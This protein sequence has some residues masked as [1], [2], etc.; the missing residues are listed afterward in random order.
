MNISYFKEII[1]IGMK[2]IPIYWDSE[3][4]TATS[5]VVE[6]SKITDENW[7][8]TSLDAWINEIDQANGIAIKLF[9]PFGMIDFDLKNTDKKTVFSDWFK[10]IESENESILHKVCIEST[11]NGGYHVYLKYPGLTHKIQLAA[12][13]S[14]NEVAAVYT[15]SLLSYCDPTPG[16]KMFHNSF[17][18]IEELT[19]DEFEILTS[20]AALFNDY[21]EDFNSTFEPVEYPIEYE[22]ACFQFDSNISDEYFEV[23]LN[24]LSLKECTDFKYG[25][26]HKFTAY[27]RNGSEAA[28]SAKVYF[29]SRRVLLFTTSIPGFPTWADYKGP[30]DKSWVLS[31]S[32][33]IYYKN[34]R[35]WTATIEEIKMMADSMGIELNHKSIVEQ[36]IIKDRTQFPY[37]IFP[38]F[39]QDYI[40]THNIQHEYIAGFMLASITAAIGNTCFLEAVD[41]Y[42]VKPTVYLAVVAHAGG[43][44]SPA[45]R[46][47]FGFLEKYDQGLYNDYKG[48]SAKY[49]EDFD[50]YEKDK[51]KNAKPQKPVL[52]QIIFK[53]ATIEMVANILQYNPKGCI[54]HADELIGFINRMNAYKQG[55][56]LQKWLSI[57][58]SDPILVQRMTRDDN[59]IT[60]YTCCIAGGIQ[61]GVLSYLSKGD[62]EH[63]G[64]YHRF[65][66]VYPD[67]QPKAPFRQI[68]RS[69]EVKQRMQLFF[70]DMIK[71]RENELKDHY[72]LMPDAR[73][74]YESWCD[75]KDKYYDKTSDDNVKGI[76]AKYQGYCLRFCL[77]I[78]VINDGAFR[79]GL[80][81]RNS[82]EKA[83][84]LTEY[85]FG[86]MNKALKILNPETPIDS[87]KSPYDK[88]YD[89][90]TPVFSLKAGLIIAAKHKVKETTFKSFLVGK[91][92]LF[93]L[94]ERG[95]YEKII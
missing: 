95:V 70:D 5:H 6:H 7:D 79:P 54:L 38:D 21:K 18:D 83:I 41:G 53:D 62:N 22:N 31:P 68:F 71:F 9:P 72:T 93:K 66:F 50:L 75:Y 91:K 4:K 24:S 51:K 1:S 52:K 23:M 76:I 48:Q 16:Y 14:G 47:A 65:L 37:D 88:I 20:T 59:K 36:P 35:D 85:F 92:D 94:K 32:R 40:K 63:N 11:R 39:I 8:N 10:I 28:Y 30:G 15:G 29:S 17:N 34:K 26:K 46:A 57:W 81:E 73:T 67:P 2:P 25:K 80:I 12:S 82:V 44:K 3:S 90:L 60:D 49:N 74:L 55:D 58:D 84:R 45:M 86:N 42:L 19:K 27:L 87:L 33:I 77:I 69:P 78:Q 64:F 89:E 43:A 56:D 13:E 61:P